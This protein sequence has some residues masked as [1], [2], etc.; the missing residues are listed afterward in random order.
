MHGPQTQRLEA[1]FQAAENACADLSDENQGRLALLMTIWASGYLE[2]VCQE[3][4]TRYTARGARPEVT[5]YVKGRLAR[6]NNPNMEKI[7]Q[8]VSGFDKETGAGLRKWA[9]GPVTESVNSI[10][11]LRNQIAHGELP[12]VSVRQIIAHFRYARELANRLAEMMG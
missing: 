6:F 8:L 3:I 1:A 2:K 9:E 12:T 10:Y 11:G 4:L 7:A 5:R